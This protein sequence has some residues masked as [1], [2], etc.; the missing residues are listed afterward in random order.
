MSLFRKEA[1]SHQSERLTGEITL[2][3]PLS[4]KLVICILV[5]ISASL[6]TFLFNAEYARKETVRGFLMPSKGVIKS[7]AT[8][9]GTIE[10]LYVNEG[11]YVKKGQKLATVTLYK[12]NSDG[13]NITNKLQNQ[14]H[15]QLTLLDD[16]IKQYEN[17]RLNETHNLIEKEVALKE[18]K[19]ALENQQSISIE[20]LQL[21]A[22]Q[23]KNIRKL[24]K[25]GYFSKFE[26][27]NQQQLILE[28][29]QE[30]ENI[31]RL[32]LQKNNEINQLTFNKKN[33]PQEYSLRKNALLREKATLK[34]Q[35]TQIKTNFSYSITASHNG[36]VT[37]IQVVEGETLS[38]SLS[39]TK[40]LLSIIPEGSK[41]VAEL[42][43]PTRSAGFIEKGQTSRLRFDAFP[44][45]RFGF[46][47]S[48]ITRVDHALVTPN[49]IQLPI[50]FNEPV[51][52]LRATLTEQQIKAY[53]KAFQLKSGM[54]FEADIMLEQRTLVEWLFEPLYSLKGRIN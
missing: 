46:M 20:K 38:H 24:N 51:Y 50:V 23:Y 21:L 10:T 31:S 28:A 16:E 52:R 48:T 36:T 14:L 41:L 42:L 17:I 49:E 3:Q 5:F 37:G 19:R 43:L 34:N 1:I 7:F 18:E 22:S 6:L 8:Q 26:A 4:I 15:A 39:Q 2:T 13:I 27:Q 9:G 30:K 45:Q 47:N 54:L 35:L 29:K 44:Y 33:L 32:L 25:N 53:G 11:Q 40:P 12:T